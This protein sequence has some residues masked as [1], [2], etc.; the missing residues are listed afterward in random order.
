MKTRTSVKKRV[1]IPVGIAAGVA[2]A[3]LLIMVLAGT[4]AAMAIKQTIGEEAIGNV[5]KFGLLIAAMLGASIT[6]LLN[7]S[8][9]LMITCIYVL[10]LILL[11]QMI[12]VFAFS[13][14]IGASL[15]NSLI[16]AAGAGLTMFFG[17]VFKK[18][19][20]PTSKRYR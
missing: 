9:K 15:L 13:G 3:L 16:I 7:K 8:S 6:R 4:V 1:N 2:A 17:L 5:S 11:Q 12:S 14:T 10:V 20:R 19:G 18:R